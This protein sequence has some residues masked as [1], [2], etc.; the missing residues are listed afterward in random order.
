MNKLEMT[1][2]I[3]AAIM[4]LTGMLYYGYDTFRSIFIEKTIGNSAR[5]GQY[6]PSTSKS[7]EVNNSGNSVTEEDEQLS[8][9]KAL[10]Y[11]K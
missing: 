8:K 3:L 9:L 1:A 7:N 4:L 6:I 2:I 10:G 11:I 5:T